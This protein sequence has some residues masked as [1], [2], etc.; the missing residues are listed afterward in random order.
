MLV[1]LEI[2]LKSLMRLLADTYGLYMLLI[3]TIDC[4]FSAGLDESSSYSR[5]PIVLGLDYVFVSI[6]PL[7]IPC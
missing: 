6:I 4:S 3:S 2:S 1:C 7:L 5:F